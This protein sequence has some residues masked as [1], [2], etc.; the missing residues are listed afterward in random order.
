VRREATEL[1]CARARGFAHSATARLALL[2]R[3]L[4][5]R[6]HGAHGLQRSVL[7]REHGALGLGDRRALGTLAAQ[8]LHIRAQRARLALCRT[9]VQRCVSVLA[10]LRLSA[11]ARLM[12]CQK[13]QLRAAR[14]RLR[15]RGSSRAFLRD[16][17]LRLDADLVHAARHVHLLLLAWLERHGRD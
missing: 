12:A 1:A 3:R 13:P 14:R 4:L 6:R 11:K 16:V 5:A 10:T 17:A 9:I 8:R 2:Q 7:V 15:S